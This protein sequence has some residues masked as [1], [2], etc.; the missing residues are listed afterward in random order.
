M[1]DKS[2]GDLN[3][4]D[5]KYFPLC[6]PWSISVALLFFEVSTSIFCVPI[7]QRQYFIPFVFEFSLRLSYDPS[8]ELQSYALPLPITSPPSPLLPA[9]R[10]SAAAGGTGATVWSRARVR[11]S[12]WFQSPNHFSKPPLREYGHS[13]RSGS[14]VS[15][16]LV[17]TRTF[18]P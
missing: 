17:G 2:Q 6:P 12:G 3:S 1:I 13:V 16:P 8:C 15:E 18:H 9:C 10:G 7:R 11:V 14:F 4:S 5:S